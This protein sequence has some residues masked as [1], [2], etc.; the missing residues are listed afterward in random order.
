[1]SDNNNA[2]KGDAPRNCFSKKFKNNYD[3]I[4]WSE[5]ENKDHCSKTK[6]CAICKIKS[7]NADKTTKLV[8]INGKWKC[9]LCKNKTENLT[10]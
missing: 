7:N 2:G 10:Q 1:M 4:N 8:F 3:E 6:N 5:K 9:Y